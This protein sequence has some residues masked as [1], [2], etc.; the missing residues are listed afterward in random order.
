MNGF[1]AQANSKSLSIIEE[2]WSASRK[3]QPSLKYTASFKPSINLFEE[4][5]VESFVE[6]QAD[7]DG[8]RHNSARLSNQRQ[9]VHHLEQEV[10]VSQNKGPV[11]PF[12]T[13]THLKNAVAAQSATPQKTQS[14]RKP[15]FS[16]FDKPAREESPWKKFVSSAKKIAHGL[17]QMMG[18]C[19]KGSINSEA[20][21]RARQERNSTAF[22]PIVDPHKQKIE[23]AVQNP[24]FQSLVKVSFE[25][26]LKSNSIKIK[27]AEIEVEKEFEKGFMQEC[28]NLPAIEVFSRRISE[29]CF[30]EDLYS[31]FKPK[32]SQMSEGQ[33][34]YAHLLQGTGKSPMKSESKLQNNFP[35]KEVQNNSQS[36]PETFFVS[37]SNSKLVHQ[38]DW[39]KK[40]TVDKTV[41]VMKTEMLY[42]TTEN[43]MMPTPPQLPEYNSLEEEFQEP[44]YQYNISDVEDSDQELDTQE[45]WKDEDDSFLDRSCSN[46]NTRLLFKEEYL[47]IRN[48]YP[49]D[50][51]DDLVLF[52]K[53]SGMNLNETEFK[54]LVKMATPVKA[55]TG[56]KVL[57]INNKRV[58]EWARDL[59]AIGKEVITQNT[60]G[61]Y[62]QVFGKVK[63]IKLLEVNKFFRPELLRNYKR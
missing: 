27:E 15:S 19:D 46:S 61:R 31:G 34:F 18:I 6:Q 48:K 30:Q 2:A 14:N 56:K 45:V 52:N 26:R 24:D 39:F 13:S 49:N 38:G 3:S 16:V 4:A 35:L 33:E 50:P 36:K 54:S 42:S 40:N 32:R 28:Q 25:D 53:R 51:L 55:K 7:R 60:F 47:K 57:F 17:G 10:Q 58:P 9:S 1:G 21:L 11:N 63:Q 62:K 41:P 23:A 37:N 29:A 12:L 44:E 59:K 8:Q 20:D 22:K 5:K 43:S